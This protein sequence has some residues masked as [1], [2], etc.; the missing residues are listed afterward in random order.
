MIIF[1]KCETVDRPVVYQQREYVKW[2]KGNVCAI[3]QKG[4]RSSF[5][6]SEHEVA[7][8]I[9]DVQFLRLISRRTNETSL[10]F[11]FL[12]ITMVIEIGS[13]LKIEF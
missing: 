8:S 7:V 4:K 3:F 1:A 2:I 10:S 11:E 9:F 6:T 12:P 5:C 13:N